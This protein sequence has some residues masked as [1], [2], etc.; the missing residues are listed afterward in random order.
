[1]TTADHRD[2]LATFGLHAEA[3]AA[4]RQA[5]WEAYEVAAEQRRYWKAENMTPTEMV[6]LVTGWRLSDATDLVAMEIMMNVWRGLPR[7]PK[8]RPAPK[9]QGPVV[10]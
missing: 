6:Y 1:M 3:T 2:H 9:T 5:F 7:R 10:R 4:E 8:P